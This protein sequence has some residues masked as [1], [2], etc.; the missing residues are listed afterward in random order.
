VVRLHEA[1]VYVLLRAAQRCRGQQRLARVS[2]SDVPLLD[3]T[4]CRFGRTVIR[5]V[6]K[7]DYGTAQNCMDGTVPEAAAITGGD[8]VATELWPIDRRPTPAAAAT[9]IAA[10]TG[11]ASTVESPCAAVWRDLRLMH[12]IAMGRRRK[13]FQAGALALNK[14]RE[15]WVHLVPRYVSSSIQRHRLL[16][17]CTW[18]CLRF[19]CSLWFSPWS[20]A[21][22]CHYRLS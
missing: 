9:G 5:S 1:C 21:S 15:L 7:L 10:A 16:D 17:C 12:A 13:R 11:V 18:L 8:A 3:A 2:R 19:Q 20:C 6:A 22:C 14:V 4:V